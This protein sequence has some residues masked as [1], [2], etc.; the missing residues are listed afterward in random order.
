LDKFVW[1]SQNEQAKPRIQKSIAEMSQLWPLQ[2]TELLIRLGVLLLE[3]QK[4]KGQNQIQKST[5][6]MLSLWVSRNVTPLLGRLSELV[7]ERQKE[8]V[9]PRIQKSIALMLQM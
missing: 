2:Q 6:R 9:K 1:A 8:Q 5:Q 7:W 4:K 3:M